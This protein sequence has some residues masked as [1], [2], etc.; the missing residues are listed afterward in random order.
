MSA[1]V[2]SGLYDGDRFRFPVCPAVQCPRGRR[3]WP[4][5]TRPV[6]AIAGKSRESQRRPADVTAAFIMTGGAR[7][8]AQETLPAAGLVTGAPSGVTSAR[9]T[10]RPRHRAAEAASGRRR[11]VSARA[12]D[13]QHRGVRCPCRRHLRFRTAAFRVLP[14]RMGQRP[15]DDV[16]A[17]AACCHCGSGQP[18]RGLAGDLFRP[19]VGT[20]ARSGSG[21]PRLHCGGKHASG[22]RGPR[23][24]HQLDDALQLGRQRSRIRALHPGVGYLE[25]LRP[26]GPAGRRPDDHDDGQQAAGWPAS[27]RRCGPGLARYRGYWLRPSAAE[28]VIRAPRGCGAPARTHGGLSARAQGAAVFRRRVPAGIPSAGLR[29]PRRAGLADHRGHG[30]EFPRIVAGPV[31]ERARRGAVPVPGAVADFACG[32]R[33]RPSAHRPASYAGRCRHYRARPRRHPG[34]GRRSQSRRAGNSGCPALPGCHL[35]GAH[36]PRGASLRRVAVRTR[37]QA[38]RQQV[39]DD[40]RAGTR[41]PQP[42]GDGTQNSQTC[43]PQ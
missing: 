2:T 1:R 36:S 40:C 3:C 19:A 6:G 34:R 30:R 38:R 29:A 15:D 35:P 4:R 10:D 24:G 28:R 13:S 20:V 42:A 7:V 12:K 32:V 37:A 23:H 14:Q 16:A 27:W 5:G 33:V 25:C 41:G 26:A 9:L 17:G 21:E 39:M 31:G 43:M 18:R 11:S 8:S 22:W